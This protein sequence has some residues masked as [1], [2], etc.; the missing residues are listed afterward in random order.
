[1]RFHSRAQTTTREVRTALYVI[2]FESKKRVTEELF[3]QAS[4]LQPPRKILDAYQKYQLKLI[5][6]QEI[7]L[8]ASSLKNERITNILNE[9]NRLTSYLEFK[10]RGE[11]LLK[12]IEIGELDD[13]IQFSA[14]EILYEIMGKNGK[15]LERLGIDITE[16]YSKKR[17]N[18]ISNKNRNMRIRRQDHNQ[19]FNNNNSRKR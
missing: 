18:Q 19:N 9:E 14:S 7:E 2:E 1:M 8:K 11:K 4:P 17:I 16:S 10:K 5:T 12:T 15:L 6:L 13:Y 3:I